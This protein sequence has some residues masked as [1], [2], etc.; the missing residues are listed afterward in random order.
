MHACYG[1]CTRAMVYARVLW[2]MHA[3]YGV[4]TRAM[5]YTLYIATDP[6]D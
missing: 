1:V 6:T 3:C 2:C 4:Y 5:V